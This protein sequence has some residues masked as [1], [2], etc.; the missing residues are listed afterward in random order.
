MAILSRQ[1]RADASTTGGQNSVTG[2]FG[3]SRLRLFG[4]ATLLLASAG[5]VAAHHSISAVYDTRQRVTVEGTITEFHFVN[6]HPYLIANG[7]EGAEPSAAWHLE[8]DNLGELAAVGVTVRT[9]RPG[10]RVVITGSRSRTEPHSLYVR[11][12]VR[13]ADG[14]EYEQVGASPRIRRR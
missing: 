13:A 9:F 4:C 1:N 14:F 12:L 6:P 3:V 8:L 5:V 2:A 7:S 10:D 11:K